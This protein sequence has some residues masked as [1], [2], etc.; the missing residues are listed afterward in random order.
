MGYDNYCISLL[1]FSGIPSASCQPKLINTGF[2]QYEQLKN[3][4][5]KF[6]KRLLKFV[7]LER[8]LSILD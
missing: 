8:I 6:N 1:D 7:G 3:I 4:L 5:L 2:H